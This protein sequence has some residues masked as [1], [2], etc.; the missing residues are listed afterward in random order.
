ML[1]SFTFKHGLRLLVD[2]H[3]A[4]LTSSD[5]LVFEDQAAQVLP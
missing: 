1:M 3:T 5:F 4:Q 2:M